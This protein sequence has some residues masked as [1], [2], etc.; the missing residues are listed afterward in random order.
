MDEE[1]KELEEVLEST[2][3][4]Y[5]DQVRA[6]KDLKRELSAVTAKL[7][8]AKRD[9]V[10]AYEELDKLN[11]AISSI[12]D[13]NLNYSKKIES[14][15]DII[16]SQDA[17]IAAL[18]S[19]LKTVNSSKR[20]ADLEASN[21]EC[22]LQRKLEESED[23]IFSYQQ[24]YADMCAN[25]VGVTLDNVPITSSTSV[26]E[27]RRYIYGSSSVSSASSNGIDPEL[28]AI[29]ISDDEDADLIVL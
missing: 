3:A 28:D 9:K 19:E 2:R 8:S 21:R 23:L 27:L 29:E 25:A 16:H 22:D 7:D 20:T 14:S 26:D 17:E 15:E 12:K 11:N 4:K 6:N 24:A 18:R 5:K 13:E 10:L 1:Y